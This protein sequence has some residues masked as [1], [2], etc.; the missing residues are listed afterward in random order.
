MFHTSNKWRHQS[1]S[2]IY[3]S[4]NC[5]PNPVQPC[6]LRQCIK[7]QQNENT[8]Y[9]ITL[10]S[11]LFVMLCKTVQLEKV[12]TRFSITSRR[13]SNNDYT[14]VYFPIVNKKKNSDSFCK[15]IFNQANVTLFFSICS[16]VVIHFAL[17]SDCLLLCFRRL[18]SLRSVFL[19]ELFLL[20]ELIHY[21][22]TFLF[23]SFWE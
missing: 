4:V 14:F 13:T 6:S 12:H 5:T 16:G 1:S 17:H 18:I 19:H 3:I 7:G 2:L 15:T 21:Q 20:S 8:A 9:F 22:G 10:L 23:R 11:V